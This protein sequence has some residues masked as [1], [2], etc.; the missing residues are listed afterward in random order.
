[1][2][3]T[4]IGLAGLLLCANLFATSRVIT[5]DITTNTTWADTVFLNKTDFTVMG[6][7][8]LKLTP[9]TVVKL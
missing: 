1:M 6:G 9:G 3:S 4:R 5:K 7:V 2:N 8:R